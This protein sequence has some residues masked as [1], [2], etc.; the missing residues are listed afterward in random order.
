MKSAGSPYLREGA[1]VPEVA[2]VGEA[3]ADIAKLALLDV[4]LDGVKLLLPRDLG[5]EPR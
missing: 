1:V 4:L 3:V 2:F 5:V